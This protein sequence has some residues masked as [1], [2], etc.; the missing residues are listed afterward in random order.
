MRNTAIIG[1]VVL[2][3][4]AGSL[5]ALAQQGPMGGPGPGKQGWMQQQ[6]TP[7]QFPEFKAQALKNIDERIKR[8]GEQRAC[9][10]KAQTHEEMKKCRPEQPMGGGPMHR[11]PG[12]QRP[13]QPPQTGVEG[14]K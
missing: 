12:Q 3:L 9:I 13:P 11:G 7:E 4:V 6:I 2:F 1:I 5:A 10:E 8:M 14:Q